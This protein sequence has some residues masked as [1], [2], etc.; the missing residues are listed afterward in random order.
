MAIRGMGCDIVAVARLRRLAPEPGSRFA[1]RVLTTEE[2]AEGSGRAD[3]PAFVARRYAAKEAAAKALGTGIGSGI[4]FH[5]IQVTHTRSGAP[6][7]ALTGEAARQ[8]AALGATRAHLTISDERDY[9]V[10]FVVIED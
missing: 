4:G 2:I 5:Q 1:R 7:L 8:L 3:F 6:G 9:A 10:A